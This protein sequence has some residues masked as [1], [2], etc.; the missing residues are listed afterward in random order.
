MK[1]YGWVIEYKCPNSQWMYH[2]DLV[3][4]GGIIVGKTREDMREIISA[5]KHVATKLYGCKKE[6]VKT[7][8]VKRT[9]RTIKRFRRE[10]V[11]DFIG[12]YELI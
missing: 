9:W 3:I 1:H 2:A 11:A 10:W 6:E 4:Y 12:L 7:R 8:I 5:V